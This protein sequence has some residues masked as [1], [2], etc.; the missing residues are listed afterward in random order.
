MVRVYLNG[1]IVPLGEARVSILDRG[2]LF[3]DGLYE[4]LRA[5][6]GRVVALDRHAARLTEGLKA[7]RI[8]FDAS[9]LA[10]ICRFVL[11]ANSL[12]DAFVY[13]QVTRGAP[14]PSDPVRT[15]MPPVGMRP[16]VL[17][18]AY[19]TPA[20]SEYSRPPTKTCVTAEDMR[21]LRGRV[22]SI[23]LMGGILAGMEAGEAGAD[24]AILVR[25]MPDGDR[26]IAESTS[27]N[28]I[29]AFETAG[30]MEVVTPPLDH[31]PILAGV[32]RDIILEESR[33]AGMPIVERPIKADE[34]AL[35]KE[36]M[37]CGTLTMVTAITKLDSK[38]VGD[39][40]PGGCCREL[41]R[42]LCA[43]IARGV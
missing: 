30:R 1:E 27:A 15:R 6:D 9:G 43:A 7:A 22:K 3:G 40:R 36:I 29:A 38:P 19:R 10:D 42:W 26:Y 4:G 17:A 34:L 18:F 12:R 24:D 23:S 39:G 28:V 14:G 8:C 32:T 37:L 2:F 16:T 35:A 21:W 5:F 11:D 31:A 33:R 25:T 41:L 13:V 20:L